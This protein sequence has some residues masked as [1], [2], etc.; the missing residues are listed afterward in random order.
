MLT[1]VPL[2]AQRFLG[3]P[4]ISI[5]VYPTCELMVI[6]VSNLNRLESCSRNDIQEVNAQA[7]GVQF[8]ALMGRHL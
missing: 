8:L 1:L 4:H 2:I 5:I 7:K 6:Q 3:R